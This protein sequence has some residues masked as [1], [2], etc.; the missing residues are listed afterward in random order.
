MIATCPVCGAD[1]DYPEGAV[2]HGTLRPRDLA[3]TMI[4][5]IDRVQLA[6]ALYH[7]DSPQL[8]QMRERV[9]HVK[10]ELMDAFDAAG[11][12]IRAEAGEIIHEIIGDAMDILTEL[13]PDGHYFGSLEGD[14][15]DIGWWSDPESA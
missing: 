10:C 5:Q 6:C 12:D 14:P 4:A 1:H 9:E 8:C 11:D 7:L 13:A 2:S 15:T 3:E